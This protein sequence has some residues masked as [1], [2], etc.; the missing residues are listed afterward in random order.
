MKEIKIKETKYEA[1]KIYFIIFNKYTTHTLQ[2]YVVLS[3]WDGIWNQEENQ[4]ILPQ[5]IFQRF[6]QKG[7]EYMYQ[8][9]AFSEPINQCNT[10]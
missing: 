6:I 9:L 7:P 8:L 2:L 10:F 3:S 4:N 1:K 5:N